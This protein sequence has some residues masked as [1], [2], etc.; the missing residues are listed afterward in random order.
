M[1]R[2]SV[3]PGFCLPVPGT[4]LGLYLLS[5]NLSLGELVHTLHLHVRS[6]R[7][8]ETCLFKRAVY[9]YGSN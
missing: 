7:R 8:N 9:E 1:G 2:G 3:N 4:R 5:S 6:T